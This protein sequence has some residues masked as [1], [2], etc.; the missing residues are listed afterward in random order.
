MPIT[1]KYLDDKLQQ[2]RQSYQHAGEFCFFSDTDNIASILSQG[3]LYCRAEAVRQG[4]LQRDCA[5]ARVL[6]GTP[7][8]VQDYARLYFAPR[9]PMLYRT[10]GLKR[11]Q[12]GWPECPRPAYL[13][14]DPIVLTLPG[15][16]VSDGNMGSSNTH[17]PAEAQED[18]FGALPFGDIYYR[19]S[20]RWDPTTVALKGFDPVAKDRFRRRHAEILLPQYIDLKYLRQIVFRS[21][22]EQALV[23]NALASMPTVVPIRID[24][25]WFYADERQR[26]YL[27]VFANGSLQFCNVQNG[28]V[29]MNIAHA[30]DGKRSALTTTYQDQTWSP[31]SAIDPDSYPTIIPPPGISWFCLNG[32]LVALRSTN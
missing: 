31:W 12:D 18:F 14:F 30:K 29:L 23:A 2:L 19:G 3:R 16:R 22:A 20:I 6:D 21:E 27:D 7:E 25:S 4:L 26:P 9:T 15:A 5:S 24:K 32:A 1:W 28:D 8:W 13:V 17:C 10:E 11:E